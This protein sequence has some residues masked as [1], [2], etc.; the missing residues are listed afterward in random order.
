MNR[1]RGSRLVEQSET[2]AS[3]VRGEALPQS[4]AFRNPL[5]QS[6]SRRQHL[7]PHKPPAIPQ[8]D[9]SPDR[10]LLSA[11]ST[12]IRTH[13]IL[14]A[15]FPT[16]P[17]GAD[18]ASGERGRVE[19]WSHRFR[20]GARVAVRRCRAGGTKVLTAPGV[21]RPFSCP[22]GP[23]IPPAVSAGCL[24]H[25]VFSSEAPSALRP[26]PRI[27]RGEEYPETC[28]ASERMA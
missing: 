4:L 10:N 19:G 6:A 2:L 5:K 21:H 16:L 18:E 15:S 12:P 13:R 28:N 7:Y 3:R 17:R 22:T 9:Q 11:L 8:S 27:G 20:S 26:W 23:K 1:T 24:V 14:P 25:P